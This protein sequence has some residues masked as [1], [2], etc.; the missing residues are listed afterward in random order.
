MPPIFYGAYILGT[1]VMGS[2]QRQFSFELSWDWVLQSIETIGP[3][4]LVG[5][6][7]CSV[8]FSA[9]GFFI[10]NY[11]WRLSVKKAWKQRIQK[12]YPKRLK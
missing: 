7:I 6:L 11:L 4:F 1:T 12:R 8:L 5:C 10:L 9:V 2:P 3:A